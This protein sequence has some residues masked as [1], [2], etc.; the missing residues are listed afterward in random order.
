MENRELEP[1]PFC[2]GKAELN[3]RFVGKKYYVSCSNCLTRTVYSPVESYC[4][5][6]WNNRKYEPAISDL[7]D[8]IVGGHISIIGGDLEEAPQPE[9]IE[10]CKICHNPNCK[11]NCLTNVYAPPTKSKSLH[12]LEEIAFNKMLEK[13][14]D[15]EYW[16]DKSGEHC[17]FT[18]RPRQLY[19]AILD[20]L[21]G[22]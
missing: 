13:F 11:G 21:E 20:L 6:V 10:P 8:P 14:I 15:G 17:T 5:A 2:G 16:A 1:C 3:G 22:K 7:S 18:G 9:Q 4:I 19:K 12:S